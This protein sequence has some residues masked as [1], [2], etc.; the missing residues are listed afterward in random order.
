MSES[1]I[2]LVEDNTDDEE[3]T[4]RALRQNRIQNQIV[5]ARDGAEALDFL[6]AEGLYATRDASIVPQLVLLDLRLPKIDGL[7]VLK[8]IRA[9]ERTRLLPIVLL[10][11]SNEDQDRF[12]AYELG[13]NSYVQKPVDFFQFTE[14]ARHLGLYWLL[15]NQCAPQK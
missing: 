6:F 3:L 7:E 5:V 10:T 1:M 9:D 11:S 4:L 12:R 8:R 13:A 14:A 15:L 2:L